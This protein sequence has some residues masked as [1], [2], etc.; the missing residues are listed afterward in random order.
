MRAGALR[1]LRGVEPS[2]RGSTRL[3]HK[4]RAL[5]PG[6][7]RGIYAYARP[8]G[9]VRPD[10]QTPETAPLSHAYRIPQLLSGF[11][12]PDTAPADI[13]CELAA[14]VDEYVPDTHPPAFG[15]PSLQEAAQ[16]GIDAARVMET[17]PIR[18]MGHTSA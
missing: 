2:R 4:T 12:S 16:A 5:R 10:A 14:E 18:R 15:A 9:G 13:Q 1:T 11:A 17:A 8:V 6:S 7:Q 3:W